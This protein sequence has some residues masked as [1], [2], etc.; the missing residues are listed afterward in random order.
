MSIIERLHAMR[1]FG[2]EPLTRGLPDDVIEQFAERDPRLGEAVEVAHAE[3]LTLCEERPDLLALDELSQIEEIQ[4]DFVNFYADDAINPYVGLAGRGPWLVTLKGAI[5]Y[6]AGGYGMLGFGHNPVAVLQVLNQPHLMANIMTPQVSQK[7]FTNRLR[8]ELGHT[9]GG[10]P[11]HS[12]LCMNSGSEAV[13]VGARI[14]DINAKLMT[15]PGG[16][17]ANQP[18]RKLSL[19]GGFHGRTQRPAQFSDSTRQNYCKHLA[20]FR[21]SDQ[22]ITV[23][24][25]DVEQLQQVFSWAETNRVFI[26]SFFL[27]PVMGEGNPGAA[28]TPEFY[29]EARRL[30]REHGA[31]MLVDS[32]QAG[33]RA[34]GVL[35][36]IDYPGFQ[37]QEAPDM[38]TY[39]KALNG[40]QYP[41]SVLAMNEHA[42]GL[43]RKGVYGNTMT[44]NPRA[45]DVACA[46]L[47]ILTEDLRQNIRD[48]GRECLEKLQAL[49]AEMGDRITGVQGTGLLFSVGL[50]SR[51]FKS[52]GSRS[53]EEYMRLRGI[54]VIHGGENSLRYTPHFRIT[55]EEIDLM[56]DATRDALLHGPVK[57]A[58]NEAVAA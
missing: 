17:Y 5:L 34:H 21:D 2:G 20:T 25:N 32:I 12:F 15:D 33:L 11:F 30:T 44:A 18:I 22:L 57:E 58:S 42:A 38:E 51:R 35:S 49:Q 46:V 36:I 26:E 27:E 24:P 52:Y 14:S 56:I 50:D 43:Y 31:L 48:R 13:T 47:D 10:C 8:R 29:A 54:N 19:K 53:L 16:R 6:D 45:L 1:N 55:S 9:R 39:S 40:G 37:E 4:S 28:I 3:F 7:K 23:E 41:L